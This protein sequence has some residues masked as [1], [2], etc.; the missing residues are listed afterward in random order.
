MLVIFSN[1][2]RP[3]CQILSLKVGNISS[4]AS[5]YIRTEIDGCYNM[6]EEAPVVHMVARVML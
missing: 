6:L 3:Y 1:A 2:V 5:L 4:A